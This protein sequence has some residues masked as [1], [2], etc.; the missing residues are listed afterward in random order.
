[1]LVKVYAFVVFFKYR[2]TTKK[3]NE[4]K[5]TRVFPFTVI[6]KKIEKKKRKATLIRPIMSKFEA[7]P[8]F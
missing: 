3:Q 8:F 4:H 5:K 6:K 7:E 1:M 2:P